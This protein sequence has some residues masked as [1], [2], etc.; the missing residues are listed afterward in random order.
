[1]VEIDSGTRKILDKY[2]SKLGDQ[3]QSAMDQPSKGVFTKDYGTFKKEATGLQNTLYEKACMFAA[4]IV[5]LE[6]SDK[7]KAAKV[8]EAIEVIQLNV[9]PASSYSLA[10]L[11]MAGFVFLGFLVGFIT[12][13]LGNTQLLISAFLIFAG[14]GLLFPLTSY[15]IHLAQK[16]RLQASNQMVLCIL[17]IMIYMRH[18]SNLEHAIKFAGEHVGNPLALDLRKIYWDIETKRFPNITESIEHY[19]LQWKDHNLQ[20]VESMHLIESSLFESNEERRIKLLEKSLEIILEGT[21]E[22]MLHYAQ[23]VKSPITMLHMLGVILPILG[24]IVLPLLGGMMGVS[25]FHVFLLYN[26]ALPVIVFYIGYTILAKRP[27]GYAQT[28][29]SEAHVSYKKMQMMSI[30]TGKDSEMLIDPKH[31]AIFMIFVFLI[32][33][34]SPFILH[35]MDPAAEMQFGDSMKLLDYRTTETGLEV[36]PFG[37]GAVMLSLLIPLGLGLG[38]G[39][40]Y[41]TRSKNLIKIRNE[42]Q[43]LETEFRGAIFQLGNRIGGGMP[44]EMAFGKVSQS[45]GGTPTGKFLGIV[46]KNIKSLGMNLEAAI[47]NEKNGALV[48]FPSPLIESTMK[49][50]VESSKKGPKIVS[51]ALVSIAEY[52]DRIN[53][54][55]ERLKDLLAEISSSMKAQVSFL[56]PLIA[57]IVVGIGTMITTIIGSLA[58]QMGAATEGG[59]VAGLGGGGLMDLFPLESLMPPFFLQM[60]VGLYVVQM[61]YV[62]TVLA[63]GIE[64]GVDKLKEED[65][66]GKNL[67]RSSILYVMIAAITIFAFNLLAAAVGKM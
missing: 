14:V 35:T 48:S 61:V 66:L 19:L 17:Y 55:T 51:K 45:L 28:D 37:I 22:S 50:L 5:N 38:L 29:I 30:K 32:I 42:T 59:D 33:G 18:T 57:G 24:L 16:H 53:K 31:I 62:L 36:G 54:V 44:A 10:I 13:L 56:T 9:S 21:Y 43:K 26:L 6:P 40:Y 67:Y 2:G 11:T 34:F 65:S 46:D 25:W 63:N 47:F 27:V 20:F 3:F 1:M 39:F 52:L 7:E 8:Q 23:D 64:N 41:K 58:T 4:S 49:V 60:V 12:F 15:P